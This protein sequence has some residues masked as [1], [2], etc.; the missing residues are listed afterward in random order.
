MKKFL[1]LFIGI[2]LTT[3][4]F[5]A[6]KSKW[7]KAQSKECKIAS[8][9]ASSELVEAQ[10]D[11][12]YLY[13]PCNILDENMD[14]TWCEAE[15]D[16]PGIGQSIV[17]E[18][19]EPMSFDEIQIVNGFNYKNLYYQNN[20]VKT[21]QLTQVAKEHF[22]QKDYELQ[23]GIEGWQSVKFKLLQTAQT[24]TIVIKD[25]YKGD[26]FDDTC[27]SDIRFL[28]K[29]KVIPF[30]GVDA[31]REV[32]AENSRMLL[33]K[34]AKNFKKDF[35]ALFQKTPYFE[36]EKE[37]LILQG[38]DDCIFMGRNPESDT[39][40]FYDHITLHPF[41]GKTFNYEDFKS[42]SKTYYL[43]TYYPIEGN[44]FDFSTIPAKY[45]TTSSF[46]YSMFSDP[47]KYELK[48]YK[49]YK[50]EYV[51]YVET[52]TAQI[53]KIDGNNIYING[54]KYTIIPIEECYFFNNP[55]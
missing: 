52:T 31:I 12:R 13:S 17:I 19:A 43:T 48:D 9:T 18:F 27:L 35:F 25:I 15:I 7:F 21:I 11:G 33:K 44:S 34:D 28:C 30:K 10:F 45:W 23:D 5:S 37:Y 49:I 1:I 14:T 38:Q 32:Q 2:F 8:V 47:P 4:L 54:E 29:G 39:I 53:I 16:G 6:E 26:N 50:T 24:V 41:D 40:S 22:Q 51:S 20:R 36:W 42:D 3:A 46:G 55:E